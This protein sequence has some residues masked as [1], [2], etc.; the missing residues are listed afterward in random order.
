MRGCRVIEFAV[1]GASILAGMLAI[2]Y[3]SGVR[4]NLTGSIPVGVYRILDDASPLKRGDI[5]LV[6]L[7]RATA[8]FAY[9]RG[10]VPRGG[11]CPQGLAPIG[12]HVMALPGDTVCVS[13]ISL[14]VNGTP[15]L[16]ST[17][18]E[19]DSQGRGLPHLPPGKYVVLPGTLW[20]IGTSSR[21]LDSRYFA[22]IPASNVIARVRALIERSD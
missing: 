7:P 1:G 21:S 18:L 10:Y 9:A 15:V 20:L 3:R 6:C 22:A 12:K 17:P 4:L 19:R 16:N 13:R 8:T 11:Y 2:V 14:S 5:V